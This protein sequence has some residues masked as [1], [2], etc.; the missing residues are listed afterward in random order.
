MADDSTTQ[1]IATLVVRHGAR[2]GKKFS[3]RETSFRIGKEPGCDLVLKDDLVSPIHT[4]IE[5]R[6][7]LWVASN[8]GANGTLINEEGIQGS[9]TLAPGDLIQIGAETLLEFQVQKQKI[10]ERQA[11][12][13]DGPVPLW[14]RPAV[15]AGLGVYFVLLAALGLWFLSQDSSSVSAASASQALE[16]T[17]ALIDSPKFAER[18]LEVDAALATS[19]GSEHDPAAEFYQLVAARQAGQDAEALATSLIER[20]DSGLFRAWSLEQQRRWFDAIA[21][22]RELMEIA[23]SLRFPA[24]QFAINRIRVIESRLAED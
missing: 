3:L 16:R 13:T 19:T 4:V 12:A 2:K 7:D 24:T 21:A 14:R 5:L 20:V 18:F 6:G 8:R 23:P 22:Y 10:R 9:R 17:K 1:S 15:L 11:K